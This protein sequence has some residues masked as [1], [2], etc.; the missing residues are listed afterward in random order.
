MVADACRVC[1]EV[2]GLYAISLSVTQSDLGV[3]FL[4]RPLLGRLVSAL[5]VFHL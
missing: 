1:G 3:N 2:L 4:G 5:N